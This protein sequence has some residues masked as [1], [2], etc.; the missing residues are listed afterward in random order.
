MSRRADDA[1]VQKMPGARREPRGMQR[2][3]LFA[4]ATAVLVLV[5]S[6]LRADEAT[7]NVGIGMTAADAPLMIADKMGFF[8]EQGINVNFVHFDAAAKMM[9]P[10][11]TGQLDVAAG[12]PSAALYNAILSNIDVKMVADKGST[13]KG[14][15]SQPLLVRKDLV[16]S[17]A[18]KSPKDLKGMTIAEGAQGTAGA[19][20]VAKIAAAAGLRYGDIKHVYMGFPQMVAALQNKAI[21]AAV[22]SEPLAT[23]A[24]RSGAAVRVVRDDVA[25][26]DQQLLALIYGGPFITAKRPLGEKFMVAYLKAVRVYDKA[27]VDG[28]LRGLDSS[29]IVSIISD[30]MNV[31]DKSLLTDMTTPAYNPDGKLNLASLR[32]DL[33][34]FKDQGYVTG[35]LDVD[36]CV[37]ASFAASAAKTLGPFKN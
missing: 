1:N 26:P 4:L 35:T 14:H 11:G 22:L 5:P 31:T 17:G 3:F 21:D 7:V 8:K 34:F 10:L 27:N 37:D 30:E 15:G 6:V 20:I 29:R 16:T 12:A 24:E 9:A 19:A 18:Y 25:Y 23:M 33:D 13:P 32:A 36:K 2:R 28:H